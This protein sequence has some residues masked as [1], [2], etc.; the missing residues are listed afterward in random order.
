MS[1]QIYLLIMLVQLV[2]QKPINQETNRAQIKQ[3]VF[4]R[5]AAAAAAAAC[6]RLIINKLFVKS[7]EKLMYQSHRRKRRRHWLP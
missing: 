1:D 4:I 3:H 5:V 7:Y 2:E 6:S